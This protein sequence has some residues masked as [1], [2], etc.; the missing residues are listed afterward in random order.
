M[1]RH[2]APGGKDLADDGGRHL[3]A[4]DLDRGLDHRER[5]AL[6]AEAV[7]AEIALLGLQQPAGNLGR[8]AMLAEQGDEAVLGQ[9][10]ELLVLPERVVGVET[11]GGELSPSSDLPVIAS[12]S[13][14]IRRPRSAGPGLL[15]RCAPRND[16][17]GVIDEAQP[18]LA[19][20]APSAA[21]AAASRAIG[22]RKGEQE[23]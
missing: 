16:E 9:A 4:R 7:E 3:P 17:C 15:G 21:C 12:D 20:T 10:E 11:D 13:E 18:S 19:F 14:A 1:G 22:T 2:L 6:D 8:L 5:E 23:T